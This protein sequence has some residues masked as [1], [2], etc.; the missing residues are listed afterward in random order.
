MNRKILNSKNYD[1]NHH[2]DFLKTFSNLRA[3]NYNIESYDRNLVKF[4][5][6]NIIPVVPTTTSSVC[7]YIIS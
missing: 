5:S 2:I 4:K 7:G 6:G 1:S 3:K